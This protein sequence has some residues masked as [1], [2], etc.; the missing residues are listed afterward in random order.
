MTRTLDDNVPISINAPTNN[1]LA[2]PGREIR[3][4]SEHYKLRIELPQMR[5]C[6]T[7]E[8]T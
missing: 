4:M 2:I 8:V 7:E 3:A 5:A 6:V 1:L